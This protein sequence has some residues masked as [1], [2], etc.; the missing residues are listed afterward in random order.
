MR[1]KLSSF[2]IKTLIIL[3]I[4]NTLTVYQLFAQ[5]DLISINEGKKLPDTIE[6]ASALIIYTY[7]CPSRTKIVQPKFIPHILILD[8]LTI[9]NCDSV[10]FIPTELID[11]EGIMNLSQKSGII[12]TVFVHTKCLLIYNGEK[13]RNEYKHELLRS[14]NQKNILEIRE[15]GR[16][17]SIKKYGYFR[18]RKGSL[19]IRTKE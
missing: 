3:L 14:V 18:G 9:N 7:T 13:I 19:I 17:E 6:T 5:G 15:L 4:I 1:K 10:F 12:D 16:K 8:S 11:I 2:T